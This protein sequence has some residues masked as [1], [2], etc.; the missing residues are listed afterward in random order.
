M[1]GPGRG[2]AA[3]DRPGAAVTPEVLLSLLLILLCIGA[4][5][6]AHWLVTAKQKRL[7]RPSLSRHNTV[8]I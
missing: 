8:R 1:V 6:L 3:G 7:D 5:D 4:L 2:L